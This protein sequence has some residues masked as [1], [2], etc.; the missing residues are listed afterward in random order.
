MTHYTDSRGGQ[1]V[2]ADMAYPYLKSALAKAEREMT[3]MTPQWRIKEIANMR[4]D[5]EERD[6][7]YAEQQAAEGGGDA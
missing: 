1:K 4:A 6:R 5:L 2:I 3:A 7:I